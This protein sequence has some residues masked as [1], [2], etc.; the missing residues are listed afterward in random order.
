[1]TKYPNNAFPGGIHVCALKHPKTGESYP[2]KLPTQGGGL[3]VTYPEEREADATALV[4]R[5]VVSIM[6]DLPH[7]AIDVHVLDFGIRKRF[8][9]ISRL[10]HLQLYRIYH[11]AAES[12]QFLNELEKTA[13][14]RHHNIIGGPICSLSQY[15]TSSDC[16]EKYSLIVINA[17]DFPFDGASIARLKKILPEASAAGFYFLIMN[18]Q[19][20]DQAEIS[21]IKQGLLAYAMPRFPEVRL[22]GVESETSMSLQPAADQTCDLLAL[23]KEYQLSIEDSP[24]E[25]EPLIDNIVKRAESDNEN[26][27]DFLS[28]PIGRTADGRNT[29]HF[30][31]GKR[32]DCNHA[33]LLGMSGTGKT[34]LLNNLILQIGEKY[35]PDEVQLYLMD[36]KDG[37]EFQFFESHPNCARIY[38]DNTDLNAASLLLEEFVGTISE[39]ARLFREHKLKN[40][41][42]Y[43]A[44]FPDKK[45]PR[46]ILI[47]DEVHRLL[48][49]G[50]RAGNNKFSKQ[51]VH[52]VKQGLAF[53]VHIILA[54]QTLSGCEVDKELMSQIKLRL[55]FR[56]SLLSDCHNIFTFGNEEPLRLKKYH[57]IYNAE[58]GIKRD[59]ILT[60]C[61]PPADIPSRIAAILAKRK[62]DQIIKPIITVSA[63]EDQDAPVTMPPPSVVLPDWMG[64]TERADSRQHEEELAL[65]ARY[66]VATSE[67]SPTDQPKESLDVTTR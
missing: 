64:Q 31:L 6:A 12:M 23:C 36:Y 65:L 35:L 13:Y 32:S 67:I 52:V 14:Y 38:L 42:A 33:F 15:N 46:Q 61:D 43:N 44:R 40:I 9:H 39:R 4:E 37:V 45:I 25:L 63:A 20:E 5:A 47:I 28:V 8:H 66:R 41:D 21:A 11:S 24:A 19:L 7:G 18:C 29:V 10:E 30:S 17:D 50:G 62:P 27:A 53:G 3:L 22:C 54:T 34:T 55:S 57:L 2:G 60:R 48:S 56:L 58:S 16:I 49:S 1:M 26:V 59:N 51:L